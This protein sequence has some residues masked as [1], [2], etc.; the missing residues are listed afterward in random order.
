MIELDRGEFLR[1]GAG[2]L[3]VAAAG[4]LVP[5]TAGA[6]VPVPTPK[7]D[8]IS[9]L[10]FAT[11]AERASRD[12]YR[13]AYKQAG[14]GFTASERRHLNKVASAKRA[15]IMRIDAA[16]GADAPLTS[17]FQ[18][19]LPK[20]A[21]R[22]KAKALALA[23]RLETLLVRVY[24][25]GIGYAEDGATRLFMGRLMAYDTESLAWLNLKA[26]KQVPSGLLSPIDLEPAGDA[27]DAYLS[28]PDDP[29]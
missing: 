4:G 3:I 11:T 27:L 7:D 26:D 2:G 21:V 19:V 18:T 28:T 24:L 9:F 14:A 25:N 29:N 15:H 8:D 6:Q 12:I 17:D 22:T 10:T 16:L 13:A 5:A 23:A 20:G 1:L